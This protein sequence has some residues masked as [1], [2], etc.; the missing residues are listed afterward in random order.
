[1]VNADMVWACNPKKVMCPLMDI[2]CPVFL[3]LYPLNAAV[4][5]DK[6]LAVI[7]DKYVAVISTSMWQLSICDKY[8]AVISD[9]RRPKNQL[10]PSGDFQ[11]FSSQNYN[12]WY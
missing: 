9:G 7:S 4:I 3:I 5:C 1:M 12:F 8:V 10:F 11:A 2:P 6:Y